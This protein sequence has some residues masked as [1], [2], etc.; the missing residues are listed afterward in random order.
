MTQR[1]L[2][3]PRP[4][5]V[6]LLP[7]FQAML[8]GE[9]VADLVAHSGPSFYQRL[10]TPLLVVWGFIYQ[11]LHPDHTAGAAVSYFASGAADMLG[12]ANKP[13]CSARLKSTNTSAYCQARQRLP[14]GVLAGSLH[15]TAQAT[16]A[17]VGDAGRWL[18]HP[19]GL[20]D[21]TTLL[22]R[23]EAP[24]VAH[25]GQP[26]NQHGAAYWVLM[27]VVVVFCLFTGVAVQV[28]DGPYRT[29]EQA[30]AAQLFAQALAESVYVGDRGFGIF[31]V[32]QAAR[33][34]NLWIVLR[35][36]RARARRLAQHALGWGRDDLVHWAP[37]PLDQCHAAMAQTP[38]AGRLI[39]VRLEKP[40]FRP[41]ELFLF[42]TLTD[43]VRYVTAAIIAL[44][45]RRWQVELD[46][47]Y[48]KS[49]LQM[50]ELTGQRVAM[51]QKE[52]LAGLL[53]YNLVRGFMTHAAQTTAQ[54]PLALSFTQAW[55]CV[56]DFVFQ[57]GPRTAASCQQFL[58]RLARCRLAKHP[59]QRHEPRK[60]RRHPAVYPSLKGSRAEAR[61][62]L[63]QQQAPAKS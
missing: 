61:Q 42:T 29:S 39:T 37:S 11:R 18:G 27:R 63:Q 47:R 28:A 50:E 12:P 51:V 35:L 48:V 24:L 41:V 34:A 21:G 9:V 52:L 46:L 49:T 45:G 6:E 3:S 7:V 40:G 15:H 13:A 26:H 33:H 20:L 43:T 10:F 58:Q 62:Q 38:I 8:P 57:P 22:L 4:S 14:A 25:Y 59:D 54:A 5:P 60:L 30:L 32:A 2:R 55:R 19:V 53:A 36:T 56:R 16:R 1:K 31:S 23:P 17:E 44:Y